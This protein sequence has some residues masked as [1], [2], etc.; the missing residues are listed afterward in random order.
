MKHALARSVLVFVAL[1]FCG[2]V[3]AQTLDEVDKRDAAVVEAWNATPLTV[4]RVLFV[5]GHPDGF[6]QY[7]ERANNVFKKGEALV[8]YAEPVGYGWKDIGGGVYQ[9]GFK[10]DFVVKTADGQIVGGH[11]DFADVV[12]KSRARNRE[13]NLLLDLNLGN[14][15]PGDYVVGYTLHDIASSKTYTFNQPFKITD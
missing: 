15:S 8:I 9:F 14:T 11:E 4:R 12:K 6:G 3:Q 10:V 13:F 1:A 2:S 5:D 7:V